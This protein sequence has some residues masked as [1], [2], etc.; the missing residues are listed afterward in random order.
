MAKHRDIWTG[1]EL[2]LEDLLWGEK[3]NESTRT[4]GGRG[5]D[6]CNLGPGLK[7]F[8]AFGDLVAA[9]AAQLR[10]RT[11]GEWR[12]VEET[13]SRRYAEPG[14]PGHQ[15]YNLWLSAQQK[16]MLLMLTNLLLVGIFI[17][18]KI[19][20]A[21]DFRL[22]RSQSYNSPTLFFAIFL[23]RHFTA[24]VRFHSSFHTYC[25]N[26]ICVTF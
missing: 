9:A 18:H 4:E 7:L 1:L 19:F 24:T 2:Y 26:L 5:V 3:L 17:Q 8:W 23:Q 12:P 16:P 14:T 22:P 15:T 11:A 10:R 25:M 6:T 13:S 20:R 21:L